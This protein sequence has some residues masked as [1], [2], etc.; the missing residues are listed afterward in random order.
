MQRITIDLVS[1]VVCPWCYLGKA[2]LELAIAD[3]QDEVSI[4]INWRPY[5]LN[6]DYP[7]EGVDQQVELA[8][9]LGGKENMDRGHA[10]LTA[11]GKEVGIDFDFDAIK[12]GPNTL[13]AHRLIHWAGVESREMQ[14]AVVSALF[15]ANFEQGRNVGDHA[16]LIEI[17][18][19][20]GLDG[21][22]IERLLATE[23]DKDMITSEI[24]AA[25][26]MG[27]NGVPF[28]I[29]DQQYAVSGAQPREVLA[30]AFRE[31]AAEKTQAQ[32]KLN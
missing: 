28:F 17:A 24:D 3:V 2:R 23:S 4:D 25:K 22:L 12:I 5:Q 16:V 29:I 13:N 8:K 27:V 11:M 10:Q 21:A 18:K 7:P 20:A 6:P 26:Q 9:K 31:I 32:S 19:E 15:K 30:N 14:N 1:D